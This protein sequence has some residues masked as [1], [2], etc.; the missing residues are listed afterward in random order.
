MSNYREVKLEFFGQASTGWSRPSKATDITKTG[1]NTPRELRKQGILNENPY[2]CDLIWR[3]NR[4]RSFME[5]GKVKYCASHEGGYVP[6]FD[7]VVIP[8]FSDV[9]PKLAEKWRA[10]EFNLGV[11]LIEG[12]E[13]AN[14]MIERMSSIIKAA[15]ALRKRNLGD[16]LRHLSHVPKR[17]R[18]NAANILGDSTNSV[19]NAWL[20][21]HLGWKPLIQDISAAAAALK[22]KPTVGKIKARTRNMGNAHPAG[23][24]IPQSRIQLFENDRRL[25]IIVRVT[26][27]PSLMER[28]G[29]KDALSI[30]WE[31]TP[32]SFV[33]D[34]FSP[35]GDYLAT[36]HAVNVMPVSKVTVTNTARR[37]ANCSCFPGDPFF[38]LTII[39]G[40][41]TSRTQVTVGRTISSSLP[42]AWAL[43][44]QVPREIS[45]YEDG[46]LIRIGNM[47][48]LTQQSLRKLF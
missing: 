44:A 13:S 6:V 45:K 8:T 35:I 23:A 16:A 37:I 34:Y 43:N 26:H 29:L 12:H 3:L 42:V 15:N 24:G 46:S 20:E 25:Q 40:G 33:I 14:M 4:Q 36:L 2:L 9:V 30:L 39:S 38:G 28:L 21:L 17:N 11:T 10:S 22:V 1:S 18:R 41:V 27:T 48:A 47:A 5:S 32:L 19:S 7:S 31:G